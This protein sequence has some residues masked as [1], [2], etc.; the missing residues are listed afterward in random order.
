MSVIALDSETH[1]IRQGVMAPPVVCVSWA[2]PDGRS[3][4]VHNREA[5]AWLHACF[6]SGLGLVF[7]NA[8]YDM[9]CFATTWPS[10]WPRVWD[11][12]DQDRV[13]D[14]LIRQKLQDIA[15]GRYRGFP[16]PGGWV[17]LRY[18]LDAVQYRYTKKHLD[19]GE[20]TWRLRYSELENILLNQWPPEARDYA[21]KDAVHTLLAYQ[22]Q[23]Q[24]ARDDERGPWYHVDQSA[25]CR[26]DFWLHLTSTV[27]IMTSR[28]A[29]DRL[30]VEAA[31]EMSRLGVILQEQG[32]LVG[33]VKKRKK[34]QEYLQHLH[35]TEGLELRYTAYKRDKKKTP[36]QNQKAEAKFKPQ[37]VT[38][39]DMCEASLDPLLEAF[40]EYCAVQKTFSADCEAYGRGCVLPLHTRFEPIAE[41]GRT[42]SS[43][44][45]LNVQIVPGVWEEQ[46]VGANIQ[47]IRTMA[48]IR[49]CF[50]PRPGFAFICA[51]YDTAEL[52]GLAQNCITRLGYS[53]LGEL[54]NAKVDPH[55]TVAANLLNVSYDEAT[56]QY[57]AEKEV[58][59]NLPEHE[60]KAHPKP[61]YKARQTGKVAN[62]G[63]P[64]GLG[65]KKLVLY[66]RK[67][68]D[69]RITE[70]QAKD[71]KQVWL[72]TY[73]EMK[74]YFRLVDSWGTG[75]NYT[76]E[77]LF[78][79]RLRG[80]ATYCAA[81][82][83]PFQGLVAD[84]AL[85]AGYLVS[86]A[87]YREPESPLFGC[88]LVNFVHDEI[89]AE[90][91]LARVHEAAYELAR[92]MV[93]GASPFLP[94]VPPKASPVAMTVWSKNAKPT[95]DSDARLIPWSPKL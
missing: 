53:R 87:M 1:L 2:L 19:K 14:V 63:F 80:G 67:G 10:L 30:K 93:V 4:L 40:A 21:E 18:N 33:G 36:E 73:P 84:M 56:K 44:Q 23:E 72:S 57:K 47:N 12:Y 85:A 82:N 75:N 6:D 32:F 95:F 25:R 81:C 59:S 90:A 43:G 65:A 8:P 94:D 76:I 34:V 37:I 39:A 52:R 60:S 35:D 61:W 92:L 62:F 86:H 24:R 28:D 26:A 46:Q 71:L 50:V 48:G 31:K 54:I 29:V 11:M 70:Q 68:Y 79:R 91:P 15:R 20:D 3:G 7:A 69:V 88:F 66:A 49:E 16:T 45:K 22:G 38:D 64:G 58:L 77:H 13:L 5:E 55:I 51:D 78:T 89:I 41:T 74:Q 9:T 17:P 27:G 42:T 83:S